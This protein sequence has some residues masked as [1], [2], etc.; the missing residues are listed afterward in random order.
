MIRLEPVEHKGYVPERAVVVPGSFTKKFPA[1][2]YNVNCALIIG[3]RKAS[4]DLKTSLNDALR[5][6]NVSV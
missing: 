2:E 3:Q 5:Q 6:N 1:G 4:T